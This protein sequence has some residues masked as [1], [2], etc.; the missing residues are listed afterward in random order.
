MRRPAGLD[1]AAGGDQRL[2]DHLAAEH[3]LPAD[4]RRAAAEQIHLERFEVEDASAG[5]DRR[6]TCGGSFASSAR[7]CRCLD[8]G[9]L[10]VCRCYMR[11]G[12]PEDASDD[13]PRARKRDVL[14][15]GG[16]FA[17]LA[18]AIALRQAL[19]DRSRWWSPIRRSRTGAA[20]HARLGHRRRGA[21]A[22]RDHRRLGRASP[23]RRS[24]SSTWWSPT[25]SSQDAVRPAFLTFDG[26]VDAGRAVR[27]HDRERAAARRARRKRAKAEGVEL[28]AGA[29]TELSSVRRPDRIDVALGDG[30]TMSRAPA[31][32]RRRR[33]LG[34][35]RAGRHPDAS[36]GTTAS[37]H[38]HHGRA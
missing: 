7:F 29:V 1:R 27:P 20:R 33:A 11:D 13:R 38:R 16:G 36:A 2:A 28:R 10:Y 25:P 19:G 21:A 18:L 30:A 23:A 6:R 4:L 12:K 17:G 15:G 26:E 8:R 32:R 34:D 24:R 5:L 3:A 22:V 37:R 35:P 14:I 9:S 31:G